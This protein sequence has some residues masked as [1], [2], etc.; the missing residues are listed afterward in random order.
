M[1]L[2]QTAAAGEKR[3][4]DP[5]PQHENYPR[6][7]WEEMTAGGEEKTETYRPH[8]APA[9]G[10]AEEGGETIQGQPGQLTEARSQNKRG[11]G[12]IQ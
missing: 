2:P 3:G 5:Q 7:R 8:Q 1:A 12:I 9:T 10:E 11:W 4:T 6:E